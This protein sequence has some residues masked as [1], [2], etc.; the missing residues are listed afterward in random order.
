MS[1]YARGVS[2]WSQDNAL[3]RCRAFHQKAT[4][5]RIC[6]ALEKLS[7]LPFGH[8]LVAPVPA[9][10]RGPLPIQPAV[11]GVGATFGR[12][13]PPSGS[14]ALLGR[15]RPGTNPTRRQ[16]G[17]KGLWKIGPAYPLGRTQ[18]SSGIR[19]GRLCSAVGAP[20]RVF[21]HGGNNPL[22]C[23]PGFRRAVPPLLLR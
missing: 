20:P 5:D 19:S 6:R 13:A 3:P 2:Q 22:Q 8:G 15:C 14:S 18:T 10:G 7:R 17:P 23:S 11:S 16:P 1:Y 9:R 12:Q 21:T 4:P